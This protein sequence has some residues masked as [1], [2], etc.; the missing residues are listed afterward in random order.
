M[1]DMSGFKANMAD[2]KEIDDF[3]GVDK[4][5]IDTYDDVSY[6]MNVFQRTESQFLPPGKDFSDLTEEE[7]IHLKRQYRFDYYKPGVYQG[8]TWKRM[9]SHHG[10]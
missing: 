4:E 3:I 8:I 9:N 5:G 2:S 7:L 1:F 6:E 10:L